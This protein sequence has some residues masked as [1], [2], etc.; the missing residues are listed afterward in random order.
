MNETPSGPAPKLSL[1]G[2]S[3]HQRRRRIAGVVALSCSAFV[4]WGVSSLGG[5]DEAITASPSFTARLIKAGGTD[6]G[7][8]MANRLLDEQQAVAKTLA[9]T[10]YIVKG[11]GQARDVALT[12]DDGPSE[13]TPQIV[14]ILRRAGVAATFFTVGGMYSTY[15]TDARAAF[16]DGY[17]VENHSLT[18][19]AMATLSLGDQATEIDRTASL[20][21]EAGLPPSQLFRP[22]YG[23]FDANT[24]KVAGKRK[25]LI[26]LWDVDTLDWERPGADA[27][28]S[29]A[30]SRVRPGSIILLH[31][32]GGERSQ[33][34][35]ALPRIIAGLRAKRLQPVTVPRLLADDP[36]RPGDTPP[37]LGQ[38]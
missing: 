31:D 24:K 29:N 23:S 15:G 1:S 6:Q 33:T 34:V 25:M 35:A 17:A 3:F 21:K 10:P 22:P 20:M 27:I 4:V 7:S 8:L 14:S 9:S 16:Q 2:E 13:F 11:G 36:P 37:A 38:A 19:S 28:V 26:V 12:F 30:L 18:H 5:S 32:G